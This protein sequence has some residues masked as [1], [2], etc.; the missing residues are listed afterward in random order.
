MRLED[1]SRRTDQI[2]GWSVIVETYKLD[3]RYYSVVSEAESR[4]RIARGEGTEHDVA[5]RAAM[6]MASARLDRTRRR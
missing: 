3:G 2:A 5:E 6:E 1:Y 4:A